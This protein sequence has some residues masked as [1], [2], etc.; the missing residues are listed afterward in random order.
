MGLCVSKQSKQTASMI[1]VE[2]HNIYVP[3]NQKHGGV[4]TYKSEANIYEQVSRNKRITMH[5]KQVKTIY[6]N[7][8]V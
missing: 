8:N 3:K 6:K 7:K 2:K 5:D 1:M 4:F